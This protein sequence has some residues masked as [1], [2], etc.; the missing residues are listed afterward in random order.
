M[1]KPPD[2][3]SSIERVSAHWDQKAREG[4]NDCVKVDASLRA[5]RM[6]FEAFVVHHD[7]QGK[8][9]LDVGCGVGDLWAHLRARGIECEYLGTDLSSEMIHRCQE[10]FPEAAFEQRNILEWEPGRTFD[11]VVAFGIHNVKFD[12]CRELLEA[13]TRRQFELCSVAAHTSIL[14]DRFPGFGPHAQAWRAEETLG[15]ALEITPYVVLRHDYLPN[16]FSLTL[17]R[18]PLIDT[19]K[20]LRLND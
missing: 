3:Q 6:R 19:R 2:L 14:T 9:I 16:D 18:Q 20:D 11:Y 1:P 7:L 17:Y 15:M 12:G 13:I 10:R 8:S 5:Q 4:D